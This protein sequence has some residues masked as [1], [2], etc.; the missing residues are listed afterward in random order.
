MIITLSGTDGV[1]KSAQLERIMRSF[2]EEKIDYRTLYVR[3]GNTPLA[4]LYKRLFCKQKITER[5][6]RTA[7]FIAKLELIFNWCFKIKL[8]DRRNRVIL[9]DRYIFDTDIDIRAKMGEDFKRGALWNFLLRHLSRPDLSLFY[10]TD[11][12]RIAARL[13]EKGESADKEEIRERIS[14]YE[15]IEDSFDVIIDSSCDIDTVFKKTESF[16]LP[17]A[18]HRRDTPHI[19]RVKRLS[20]ELYGNKN[21]R[22]FVFPMSAGNSGSHN[23][24]VSFFGKKEFFAK[25]Y[26]KERST[27]RLREATE[28]NIIVFPIKEAAISPIYRITL[29]RWIEGSRIEKTKE[30]ARRLAEKIR[31]LHSLP[32]KNGT[33]PSK[34]TRE[35]GRYL[36]YITANRVD[37]A[38]K[39]ELLSYIN[40]RKN[41]I[42]PLAAALLH[43][44]LH[45]DNTIVTPSGELCLIDTQDV[46]V[47]DPIREFV[48][49]ACFHEEDEVEFWQEFLHAYFP[50]GVSARERELFAFYCHVH[51][52]RMIVS[53]HKNG[54]CEDINRIAKTVYTKFHKQ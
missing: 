8:L 32:I 21:A 11:E 18:C 30:E 7:F 16:V 23:Y 17:L 49:A 15:K 13:K 1:G 20:G 45:L 6:I 51:A 3:V 41:R 42:K 52:L 26:S 36:F 33:R 34:I 5:R 10:K 31:E 54:Q 44:D 24:S 29:S 28:Q 14:D 27:K 53:A 50:D 46:A 25:I 43:M 12:E 40:E 22:A 37:F 48:Y 4:S 2:E 35:I 47:S 9:C 38:H 39:K 19:R